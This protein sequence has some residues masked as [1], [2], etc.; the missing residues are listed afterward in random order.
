LRSA[1]EIVDQ[2]AAQLREARQEIA[3]LRHEL[4]FLWQ[5]ILPRGIAI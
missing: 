3:A 4:I 5:G 2:L 1:D